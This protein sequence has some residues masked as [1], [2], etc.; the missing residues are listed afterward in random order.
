[1][2][3]SSIELKNFD[4]RIIVAGS[5]R[6]NNYYYFSDCIFDVL[7]DFSDQSV[8]FISGAAKTGADALIIRWCKE[9]NCPWAEFPADWDNKGLGAGYI[10]NSEMALVA[11]DLIV[12]FDG[13]S[14]GTTH[15]LDTAK[16]KNIPITEFR[17]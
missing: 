15:M 5:R 11:T 4:R 12:F 16:K 10:R 6:Y 17:I 13:V 14:K 7:E 2:L 9:Y 8:C 1:M 3:T